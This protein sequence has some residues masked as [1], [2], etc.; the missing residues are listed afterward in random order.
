MKVIAYA[1]REIKTGRYIKVGT[2]YEVYDVLIN[3]YKLDSTKYEVIILY[4]KNI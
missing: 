4:D 1:L 2:Q 3:K